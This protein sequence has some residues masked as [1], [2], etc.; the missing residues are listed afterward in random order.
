MSGSSVFATAAL[1]SGYGESLV[2]EGMNKKKGGERRKCTY[3][4]WVVSDE[5]SAFESGVGQDEIWDSVSVPTPMP[6]DFD[7][8]LCTIPSVDIDTVEASA[9]KSQLGSLK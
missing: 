6:E 1:T 3:W 7:Q 9:S 2:D 5:K 4:T 8:R